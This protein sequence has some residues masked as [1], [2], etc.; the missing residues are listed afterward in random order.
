MSKKTYRE[1]AADAACGFQLDSLQRVELLAREQILEKVGEVHHLR[2]GYTLTISST[3]II[4][5]T[6]TRLLLLLLLVLQRIIT[7]TIP[8]SITRGLL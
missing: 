5:I 7:I 8:I 4:T 3:F 6:I 1:D 2:T